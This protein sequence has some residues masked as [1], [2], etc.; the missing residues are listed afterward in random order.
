MDEEK[1]KD[2]RNLDYRDEWMIGLKTKESNH[3]KIPQIPIQTKKDEEKGK[4][5][6]NL[7]DRDEWMIGLE[8][9]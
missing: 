5:C 3:P 4:E 1:G 8:N 6:R 2:C 9:V 7:D